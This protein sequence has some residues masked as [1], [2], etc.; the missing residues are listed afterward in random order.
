[1]RTLAQFISRRRATR[2]V[3]QPTI[4]PRSDWADA[5]PT[6]PLYP[7]DDVRFLL[8][9]HTGSRNNYTPEEVPTILRVIYGNHTGDY[10]PW[11]DIAYNFMVDRFGG[12]WEARAGSLGGPIRGDATG[13][14]QGHAILGCWLGNLKEEAPTPESV[15]SMTALWAWQASLH[16]ID[17]RPGSEVSF[18]SR[19]SSRWPEGTKV[20]TKTIA[21]HRDMSETT[22]PGDVGYEVVQK[23]QDAVTRFTVS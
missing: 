10:G 1:M 2:N 17:V 23:L 21:G 20:T 3:P 12:I 9:H 22:C 7:E 13:G 18:I 14:S 15:E 6:G 11:S 5:P 4:H 19:G 16:N 8:T